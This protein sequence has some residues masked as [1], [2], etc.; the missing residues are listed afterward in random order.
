MDRAAHILG[1]VLAVSSPLAIGQPDCTPRLGGGY[2]CYN[3][4]TGSFSD[5]TPRLPAYGIGDRPGSY[6]IGSHGEVA[7][8]GRQPG[9][10]KPYGTNAL[11]L[12][13]TSG[14]Y[15]VYNFAKGE[16]GTITPRLGG[17]YNMYNYGTGQ[18]GTISPRLGGG[19]TINRY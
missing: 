10:Y 4:D 18:Y 16:F 13:R 7:P 19:F 8:S 1:L 2:S 11:K 9:G 15:D 14:G 12:P 6:R 3:Y 17:G 5:I